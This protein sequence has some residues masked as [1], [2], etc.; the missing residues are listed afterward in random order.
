MRRDPVIELD[1]SL[2]YEL[3]DDHRGELL[4]DRP[5]PEADVR[6]VRDLPLEVRVSVALLVDDAGGVGHQHRT[7]ELAQLVVLAHQR[8]DALRLRCGEERQSE[9]R[10]KKDK[11]ETACGGSH[12]GKPT[13]AAIV[14]VGIRWELPTISELHVNR[15]DSGP[16]SAHIAGM[17]SILTLILIVLA[18]APTTL[19][20]TTF[21][22]ARNGEALFGRN[23]D[24]EIGQGYVMT[25]R[26]GLVKTSMAGSL[27]W[28][29]RYASVTF[30]QWGREFPMDGMNEGGLVVALMWLDGS[31]YPP[32]DERPPLRVLEWIQYNLDNYATVSE[33]LAH[34]GETRI[35]GSTPLH[36]LV[37]DASGDAATIEFLQGELVVHRGAS[38]P[39]A[40]LTND[41]YASSLSHL[42]QFSGFGGTRPA[43]A[44]AGSLDRFARASMMI[45]AGD[46]SVD[47]AFEILGSVAQRGSTR[48]SVVY[49]ATRKEISWVSDRNPRRR[50]L[51][52]AA[53][54]LDCTSEAKMLDVHAEVEGDVALQMEPYSAQRNRDLV[55]SSYTST[56]FTKN[57][58]LHYAEAEADHAERFGVRGRG[59]GRRGSDPVSSPKLRQLP[60][61]AHVRRCGGGGRGADPP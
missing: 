60:A 51:R 27:G 10:E 12:E 19:A 34:A 24:F 61:T 39:S 26:R 45:R 48:W 30:N 6:R 29:S 37:A 44:S 56:S 5:E 17:R 11:P 46:A 20:C 2:G 47:R 41:T 59:A 49:D 52:V 42:H 25:N 8:I 23:Y 16:Q 14:S 33:L 28:T 15:D 18:L 1:L 38:L 31:L 9:G 4:G 58:P 35:A 32:R 55:L 36:Y 13:P 3:H 57:T 43:P 53:I 21:C 22:M 40:V 50:S 54:Q 7:V